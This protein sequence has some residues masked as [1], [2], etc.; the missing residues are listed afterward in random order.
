MDLASRARIAKNLPRIMEWQ[1]R[2][3]EAKKAGQSDLFSQRENEILAL[4]LEEAEPWTV[5]EALQAE[6]KASGQYISGHPLDDFF[7]TL[8]IAN[9]YNELKR[10][11]DLKY[12]S[13][14]LNRPKETRNA[15]RRYKY[16]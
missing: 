10:Q 6:F 2:A 3:Q 4:E 9:W 16:R 11:N 12:G 15:N 8:E 7:R 1:K 13:H 14:L 5:M